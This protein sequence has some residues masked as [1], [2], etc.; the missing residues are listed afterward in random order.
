MKYRN[1]ERQRQ[2]DSM[3]KKDTGRIAAEVV[4]ERKNIIVKLG[5][6]LL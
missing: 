1:K 4:V 2:R 3:S 6:I 5:N